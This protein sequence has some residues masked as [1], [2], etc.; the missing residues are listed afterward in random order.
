MAKPRKGDKERGRLLT[1]LAGRPAQLT[2]PIWN[3]ELHAMIGD[4]LVA[5]TGR[6]NEV[7]DSGKKYSC[8]RI[9][10]TNAG[11]EALEK[12]NAGETANG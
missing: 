1:L 7:T 10:I 12:A 4:G 3:E 2:L 11:R 9:A 6:W 5:V 8:V